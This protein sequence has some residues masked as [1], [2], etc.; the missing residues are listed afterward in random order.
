M[1]WPKVKEETY[2]PKVK[3]ETYEPCELF[4]MRNVSLF[5]L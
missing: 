5:L 4:S 3:V 2:E 1:F